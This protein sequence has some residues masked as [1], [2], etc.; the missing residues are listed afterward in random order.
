MFGAAAMPVSTN[1][2]GAPVAEAIPDELGVPAAPPK[3]FRF[4][5]DDLYVP[6]RPEFA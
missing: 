4:A 6:G 2:A 1:P 3:V 5:S